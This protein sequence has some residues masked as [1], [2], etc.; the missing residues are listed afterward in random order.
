MLL[1]IV[2]IL[3]Y[4]CKFFEFILDNCSILQCGAFQCIDIYLRRTL[5]ALNQS[6][7][8]FVRKK[9]T[10]LSRWKEERRDGLF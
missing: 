7:V 3:I 4:Y 10:A 9:I 6:N 8:M 5:T 1:Y 2:Y